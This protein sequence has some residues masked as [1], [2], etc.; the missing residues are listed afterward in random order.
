[1]KEVLVSTE[2]LVL[3]LKKGLV[4]LGGSDEKLEKLISTSAELGNILEQTPSKVL[5]YLLVA[6]DPQVSKD[7]PI[8]KEALSVLEENWT[9]Y[10]NTFSGTPTQV[11]RALL[12]QAIVNESEKNQQVAIAFVSIARNVLSLVSVG[13]ED[14]V[15]PDLIVNI[16]QELN[17]QAEEEWAAPETITVEE[18]SYTPSKSI[19]LSSKNVTLDRESLQSGIEKASGPNNSKGEA[20]SG[21]NVWTNSGEAWVHKFTPLITK[22]IA[23]IVD[24]A[25]TEVQVDFSKPLKD[26]SNAVSTH[27]D[28]AL[29]SVSGATIGLQR[30]TALIWWKESFYSS[31][32]F[33]SYRQMPPAIAA[34][35]MAF[36]LFNQVPTCSPASV[37]AFLYESVLSLSSDEVAEQIEL[38]ELIKEIQQ[39]EYTIPLSHYLD[40]LLTEDQGRGLLLSLLK[41]NSRSSSPNAKGFRNLTGLESDTQL[42]NS[43]WASW[44]FR[45][46][47]ATR[48]VL[49]GVNVDE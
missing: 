8:V 7:D 48:A 24:T 14:D 2:V 32:A 40:D 12:L 46:L 38:A 35:V 37:T 47:Q 36:D 1:M 45:E 25:F 4:D 34:I 6:L 44:I 5:P 30:R 27:I 18:F 29:N 16:E 43:D 22:A 10:F 39:S 33:C 42:S 26:L 49:Q 21:N 17:R 19:K 13:N 31:S 11:V 41:Y 28:S 15:W 9:T 23:D 20:T 3:F